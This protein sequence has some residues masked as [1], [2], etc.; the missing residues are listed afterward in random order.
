MTVYRYTCKDNAD[1]FLTA[2]LDSEGEI[3]LTITELGRTPRIVYLSA[4]DTARLARDLDA[5]SAEQDSPM[6]AALREE[7][8]AEN[9]RQFDDITTALNREGLALERDVTPPQAPPAVEASPSDTQSLLVV[10]TVV[11]EPDI[12]AVDPPVGEFEEAAHA[13][14]MLGMERAADDA[15]HQV[16][17]APVPFAVTSM[18][19]PGTEVA[20]RAYLRAVELLRQGKHPYTHGA[21]LELARYLNESG[22]VA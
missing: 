3:C 7:E 17:T 21:A 15:E 8:R 12:P 10:G 11:A 19:A 20:E 4:D 5:L 13:A 14:G 1:D 6:L 2:R 18:P 9:A 16:Q 22:S